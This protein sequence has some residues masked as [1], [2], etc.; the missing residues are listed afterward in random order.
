LADIAGGE[1]HYFAVHRDRFR[2]GDL[3]EQLK[4][5]KKGD[6]DDRVKKEWKD[7]Y[8]WLL[9]PAFLLLLIEACIS[10]RRRRVLYPEEQA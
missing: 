5:L 1:G 9:F 2:A 4:R 10:G 6:L 8:Q 3:V 7:V